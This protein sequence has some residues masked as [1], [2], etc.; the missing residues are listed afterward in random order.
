MAGFEVATGTGTKPLN[1]YYGSKPTHRLTK[2]TIR[3]DRLYAIWRDL[4]LCGINRYSTF[5]D[6]PNLARHVVLSQS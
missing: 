5:P 3:T 1:E 4:H 2:I 6:L